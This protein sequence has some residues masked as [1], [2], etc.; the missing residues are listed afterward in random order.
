[1]FFVMKTPLGDRLATALGNPN[2]IAVFAH[3]DRLKCISHV[4]K[5]GGPMAMVDGTLKIAF[6]HTVQEYK[7]ERAE[8]HL[9]QIPL[10][11]PN[12]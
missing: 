11:Y 8:M 12:P 6:R 1:M 2:E 4:D 5:L 10:I 9:R 3:E 7:G